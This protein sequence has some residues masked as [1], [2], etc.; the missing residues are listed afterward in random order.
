MSTAEEII[1]FLLT[2]HSLSTSTT[3]DCG[4]RDEVRFAFDEDP[5]NVKTEETTIP[6]D[7]IHQ[8]DLGQ[9]K[10]RQTLEEHVNVLFDKMKHGIDPNAITMLVMKSDQGYLVYDGNHRLRALLR[11]RQEG[12]EKLLEKF[13][14]DGKIM[15]PA[16]VMANNVS[17]EVACRQADWRNQLH[18]GLRDDWTSIVTRMMASF[19]LEQLKV[20]KFKDLHWNTTFQPMASKSFGKWKEVA[21]Q[22][23]TLGL[24][25]HWYAAAHPARKAVRRT[26]QKLLDTEASPSAKKIAVVC[27]LLA[28]KTFVKSADASAFLKLVD[29]KWETDGFCTRLFTWLNK[30][31][32]K[33]YAGLFQ[34]FPVPEEGTETEVEDPTELAASPQEESALCETIQCQSD[35]SDADSDTTQ[36]MEV[37]V[38]GMEGVASPECVR[39]QVEA[40]DTNHTLV[41]ASPE[42][43]LS[44]G[45]SSI[46]YGG[47]LSEAESSTTLECTSN[48][49]EANTLVT[50]NKRKARELTKKRD[51]DAVSSEEENE[52]D[53]D[54]PDYTS[55]KP[56]AKKGKP[57]EMKPVKRSEWN[58]H[59]S[60][61]YKFGF[62]S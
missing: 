49:S 36:E 25:T 23:K 41:E 11:L 29:A 30:T 46:E 39:S 62:M 22:V 1:N 2:K 54:D 15:I 57:R 27:A 33:E 18:N 17:H 51:Q 21:L 52:H 53:E 48:Q 60:V 26:I 34:M 14:K 12:H 38:T 7:E 9:G 37:A 24:H 35:E 13:K 40:R 56:K 5:P 43:E 58:A 8:L 28:G 61:S 45:G 16:L 31:R 10:L 47:D 50:R 6:L 4:G 42:E 20:R 3:K 55:K 19:T 59:L 32:S 44:V